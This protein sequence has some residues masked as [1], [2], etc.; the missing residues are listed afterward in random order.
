MTAEEYRLW[1]IKLQA[2]RVGRA[3]S[4]AMSSQHLQ[5]RVVDYERQIQVLQAALEAQREVAQREVEAW[6]PQGRRGTCHSIIK[7]RYQSGS[8]C[9][10][11]F[12]AC[13]P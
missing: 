8:Q 10:A 2:D 4:K 9:P 13:F 3:A 11:F 1:S 6:R 5:Q 12:S 7:G